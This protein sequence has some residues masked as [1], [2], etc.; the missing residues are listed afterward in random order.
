MQYRF[1]AQMCRG[2]VQISI[3]DPRKVSNE[4]KFER[5]TLIVVYIS[6][7]IISFCLNTQSLN[8]FPVS[9]VI[10]EFKSWWD[11]YL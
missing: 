11:S 3:L 10:N 7:W 5:Q 6:I 1:I 4:K 8:L 9:I 2:L